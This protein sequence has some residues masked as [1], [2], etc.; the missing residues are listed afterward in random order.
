MIY[1]QKPKKENS[2]KRR[3]RNLAFKLSEIQDS[4][5]GKI[6]AINEHSDKLPKFKMKAIG[7]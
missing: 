5:D 4:N 2:K 7:W 6:L 1:Y 3:R